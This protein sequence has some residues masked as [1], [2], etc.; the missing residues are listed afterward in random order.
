[1]VY[2][3]ATDDV[4]PSKP[5][6]MPSPP[7]EV[8]RVAAPLLPTSPPDPF[9]SDPF[10]SD[11]FASTY[12]P[13]PAPRPIAAGETSGPRLAVPRTPIPVAGSTARQSKSGPNGCAIAAMILGGIVVL[14]LVGLFFLGRSVIEDAGDFLNLDNVGFP[15]ANEVN[16]DDVRAGD[17]IN[18]VDPIEAGEDTLV[19][20]LD[21]VDCSEPHDAEMF[22]LFDLT[23]ATWPGADEAYFEGDSGCFDLFE[24][25]V[26]VAYIDSYYFYEVYTPTPD[27]WAAGDRTV[28]C[29]IVDPSGPLTKLVRNSGE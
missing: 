18:F 15:T 19:S 25:Y 21:L 1:M 5:P 4:L 7:D 10:E 11:P 14:A 6:A 2:R 22:G 23:G 8:P 20:T 27:S 12:D 24:G 9:G 3:Y 17:C 28:A 13:P 16:W 29:T 26:G